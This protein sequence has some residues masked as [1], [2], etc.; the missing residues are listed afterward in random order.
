M[1]FD[2]TARCPQTDCEWKRTV[3]VDPGGL[4]QMHK[5]VRSAKSLSRQYLYNHLKKDHHGS[6]P[7]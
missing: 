3:R 6:Q 4:D 7:G 2:Q 5:A 1:T